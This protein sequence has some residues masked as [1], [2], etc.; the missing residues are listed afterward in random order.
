MA[1]DEVGA[2]YIISG[3]N[4][5]F[6]EAQV[7]NRYAAGLFGVICEISLNI[8]IRMV[9]DDFDG[10]F[11]R[12]NGSVGAES[13]EHTAL[14]SGRG[15][16]RSF[17]YFERKTGYIIVNAD[18][19]GGFSAFFCVAENSD[20]L[21]GSGVL[22]AQTIAPA[23]ELRSFKFRIANSSRNVKE[24]RFADASGFFCA[25]KN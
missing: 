1:C 9:A 12:A 15:G 21:C 11:V 3:L 13:P 23:E 18:S 6:S 19:K 22:A 2:V 5:G 4:G 14:V 25:V 8:A 10:F 24:K 7:R 16:I 17:P 20:Y